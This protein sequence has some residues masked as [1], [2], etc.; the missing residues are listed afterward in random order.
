MN[1][2]KDREG[3]RTERST[4]DSQQRGRETRGLARTER[5]GSEEEGSMRISASTAE[6]HYVEGEKNSWTWRITEGMIVHVPLPDFSEL[7]RKKEREERPGS[8]L[9]RLVRS[10]LSACN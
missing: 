1:E 7:E 2:I 6:G 10:R 9:L 8:L 4:E 5:E 3:R